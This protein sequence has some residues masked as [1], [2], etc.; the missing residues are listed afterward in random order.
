MN[1]PAPVF[2]RRTHSAIIE[3]AREGIVIKPRVTLSALMAFVAFLAIALS[4][5]SEPTD[6]WSKAIFS[7]AIAACGLALLGML[8]RRG[9]GRAFWAGFFVFGAGYLTL[10]FGPWFDTHV[11]P[12]LLATP[13]INDHFM[14]MGYTPKRVGEKVWVTQGSDVFLLD[15]DFRQGR[16]VNIS[17]GPMGGWRVLTS[18]AVGQ[19]RARSTR[20]LS[21]DAYRQLWHA[22]LGLFFAFVGGIVARIFVGRDD[23]HRP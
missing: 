14:N 13:V 3:L 12:R 18:A 22:D 1:P 23:Q 6:L 8:F 15:D 17:S 21:P 4:S 16:V 10:C 20:A 9:P 11:M 2:N 5:L 19:Y 7:L